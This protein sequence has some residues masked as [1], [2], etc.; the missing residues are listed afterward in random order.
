MTG[1]GA[2]QASAADEIGF[3]IRAVV[4]FHF[5]KRNAIIITLELLLVMI[6]VVRIKSRVVIVCF[7]HVPYAHARIRR[8]RTQLATADIFHVGNRFFM[9]AERI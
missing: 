6:D 4:G 7:L 8:R 3:S 2:N 9:R 1:Q 5:G